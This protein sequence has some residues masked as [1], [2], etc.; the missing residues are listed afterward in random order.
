MA[1]TG[2]TPGVAGLHNA[3]TVTGA[4]PGGAVTVAYVVLELDD[5]ILLATNELETLEPWM[6]RFVAAAILIPTFVF[7]LLPPLLI[8]WA[9]RHES[10]AALC[11]Q[12]HP[13]PDWS[14]RCPTSVVVL[15]L[16]SGYT[17]LLSF[18]LA[19]RPTV[20]WFYTIL[21]GNGGRVVTIL[22]GIALLVIGW[23]LF[24]RK[25]AALWATGLLTTL[26]GVATASALL[27]VPRADWYRALDYPPRLIEEITAQAPGP[28]WGTISLVIVVTVATWW[29]LWKLREQ[30][31]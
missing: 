18:P 13:Q 22:T 8:F 30:F 20:P 27:R 1:L 4:S 10:A 23:T 2:P 29:V 24:Q 26:L 28:P 15:A 11:H 3:W 19:I 31:D 14:D 16:A 12:E 21:T 9:W 5:L 25:R 6:E 7:G 17:G